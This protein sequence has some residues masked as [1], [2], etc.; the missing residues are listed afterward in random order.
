MIS[1]PGADLLIVG[2]NLSESRV[3]LQYRPYG[4]N[5]IPK[6]FVNMIGHHLVCYGWTKK[7]AVI[8][9]NI[10]K[11]SQFQLSKDNRLVFTITHYESMQRL[12]TVA[13]GINF[14]TQC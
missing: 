6:F 2:T 10:Q 1:Q 9:K 12:Q 11:Y 13:N 5:V 8:R 3:L 7:V 4:I 14:D